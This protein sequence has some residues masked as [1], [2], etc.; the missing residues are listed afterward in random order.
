[1]GWF[2]AFVLLLSL[3]AVAGSSPLQRADLMIKSTATEAQAIEGPLQALVESARQVA[4]SEGGRDPV[5]LLQRDADVIDRRADALSR[6]ASHFAR[7]VEDLAK[8][9]S[10][11]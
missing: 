2:T 11:D 5:L 4:A 3:P 10:A 1:M 9:L 8:A 7:A 6:K